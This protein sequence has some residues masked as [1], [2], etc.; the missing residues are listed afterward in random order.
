MAKDRKFETFRVLPYRIDIEIRYDSYNNI[1]NAQVHKKTIK[2]SDIGLLKKKIR[3]ALD[4]ASSINFIPTIEA[5]IEYGESYDADIKLELKYDRFYL[6]QIN[7][8]EFKQVA[9]ATYKHIRTNEDDESA[10]ALNITS[11]MDSW[12]S[13]DEFD[14]KAELYIKTGNPQSLNDVED[15]GI[16]EITRLRLIAPYS[17]ELWSGLELLEKAITDISKKATSLLSVDILTKAA[18]TGTTNLITYKEKP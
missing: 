8:K 9:W 4:L 15:E 1:F 14:E 2:D 6:G 12:F 17:D 16:E 18:L 10:F 3:D 7:K 5:T 11:R 13:H